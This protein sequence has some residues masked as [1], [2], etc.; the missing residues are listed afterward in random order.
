MPVF[1]MAR[2][3]RSLFMNLEAASVARNDSGRVERSRRF[4]SDRRCCAVTAVWSQRLRSALLLQAILG[5]FL[6]GWQI[7]AAPAAATGR[8]M[9][10]AYA[11]L[12]G[13]AAQQGQQTPMPRPSDI[14]ARGWALLR[15][16]FYVRG[17]NDQGIGVQLGYSLLRVLLGF[18]L[19]AMVAIPLGFAD[20]DEPHAERRA[21]PDH[22]G[23]AAGEPARLDADCA[24]HD[25]G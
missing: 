6:G 19:A 15:D 2:I 1:V 5:L 9:D 10:P 16:P 13:P 23:A 20:R 12:L 17:T 21:R 7:A 8:A 4:E 11:A 14:A 22:P 3:G 18:G 24:L 25:Q